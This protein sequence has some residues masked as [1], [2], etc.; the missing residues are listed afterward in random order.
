MT[1]RQTVYHAQALGRGLTLLTR[2]AAAAPSGLTVGELNKMTG[3]PKSTLVRLIAVLEEHGFLY[4]TDDVPTFRVGHAVHLLAESYRYAADVAAM[5]SPHLGRL[6]EA[7]GQTANLGVIDR[8]ELLHLCV[9]EP[10]RALRFR[11]ANGSRDEIHATGLGK[12]LLAGLA[13]TAAKATLPSSRLV[14]RTE[15][16]ITSRSELMTDVR[17]SRQRGY[18][19]D[20]GEGA[21]GVRCLAVPVASDPSTERW[22]AAISVAGPAAEL[23]ADSSG[24][25]LRQLRQTAGD[26][27]DDS[28]LMAAV[29]V[30]LG[31][32][33]VDGR[34]PDSAAR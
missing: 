32:A 20:D 21:V 7:T 22:S 4:R 2:V 3:Y 29:D 24:A 17:R 8:G 15:N 12:I 16:T 27:L 34:G 23:G 14:R 28:E 19:I 11:S 30:Y 26:M 13:E 33:V 31:D 9:E 10:D 18:A 25:L 5:A 1:S 6:A